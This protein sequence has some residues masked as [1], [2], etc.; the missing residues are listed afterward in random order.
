[1]RNLSGARGLW[2]LHPRN[3]TQSKYYVFIIIW[4]I[5]CVAA[6]ASVL[7]LRAP[8]LGTYVRARPLCPSPSL[9]GA[10]PKPRKRSN[11]RFSCAL[12]AHVLACLYAKWRVLRSG[13]GSFC[14]A[15]SFS[16]FFGGFPPQTPGSCLTVVFCARCGLTSSRAYVLSGGCSAGVIGRFC[17]GLSPRPAAL[18]SAAFALNARPLAG[19]RPRPLFRLSVV[20]FHPCPDKNKCL[21][22]SGT[23][24]P[25]TPARVAP[26][27]GRCFSW[28]LF[29]LWPC[30]GNLAPV[31]NHKLS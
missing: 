1:M 29:G 16:R 8:V 2:P 13:G 26:A 31:N 5:I 17:V 30:A 23:P 28:Y 11:G 20:L 9:V 18:R 27:G 22:L 6:A 4:D 10:S 3:V 25:L 14:V 21:L 19:C 24:S 12:R 15:P 7:F